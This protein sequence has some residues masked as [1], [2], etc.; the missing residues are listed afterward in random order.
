MSAIITFNK[1]LGAARPAEADHP[2]L[3]RRLEVQEK[4]LK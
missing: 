4:I 3:K 1:N 2:E